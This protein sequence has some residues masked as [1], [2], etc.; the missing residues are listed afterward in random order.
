M[1]EDA[2][3]RY[4][5]CLMCTLTTYQKKSTQ[6]SV[7][8]VDVEERETSLEIQPLHLQPIR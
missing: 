1:D 6:L 4:G 3:V 2:R 5:Q 8:K 7:V